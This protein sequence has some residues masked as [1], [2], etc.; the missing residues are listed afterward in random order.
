MS[1][2][3]KLHEALWALRKMWM[4]ARTQAYYAH[5]VGRGLESERLETREENIYSIM[6]KIM[7]R[8]LVLQVEKRC[9]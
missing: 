5:A 4:D 9:S 1:E 3:K 6:K 8:I 2:Y 7:H